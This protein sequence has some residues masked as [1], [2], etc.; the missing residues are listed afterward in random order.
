MLSGAPT[1]SGFTALSDQIFIREASLK[2]RVGSETDPKTVMIYGW[3]DCLP[4]HI[5]KY[6][7][8]Y[9]ELYPLAKQ[10]VVLS[11]IVRA[12]Y[13]DLRK[14]SEHMMPA[15]RAAFD[16]AESREDLILVHTMS[17]TGAV[18]YGATLNAYRKLY[19]KALPHQLLVLDSTP[20]STDMTSSNVARWSRAMAIGT[21]NWFPWP[22]VATQ[23]IWI[24]FLY[25]RILCVGH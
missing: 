5:V 2:D 13:S 6:A 19:N 11:P 21:A 10:V 9:R 1:F 24:I 7:D 22:F 25:K 15:L 20:G 12:M 14:C 8:G 17:N 3:G 16:D 4:K 18:N 23:S